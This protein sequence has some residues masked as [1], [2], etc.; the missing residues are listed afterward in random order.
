MQIIFLPEDTSPDG[1]IWSELPSPEK[2]KGKILFKGKGNASKGEEPEESEDEDMVE[3]DDGQGGG[4]GAADGDGKKK[5]KKGKRKKDRKAKM[6]EGQHK[7]AKKDKELAKDAKRKQ[8]ETGASKHDSE[9]W[10]R[11]IYLCAVKFKSFT[12]PGPAYE[13]ASYSESKARKLCST[14]RLAFVEYNRKQLA[15]IYPWGGRVD[16]SNLDPG[17]A[18]A[19]GCQLVAF[20]FQVLRCR[21]LYRSAVFG[22]FSPYE[23][24]VPLSLTDKST[25]Q[26]RI[27]INLK[28]WQWKSGL[29]DHHLAGMTGMTLDL[30]VC[31]NPTLLSLHKMLSVQTAAGQNARHN[32]SVSRLKL[33]ALQT[34]I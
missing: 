20:N 14:Q 19:A 23:A 24:G 7:G 27:P 15:R 9:R 30:A 4:G 28:S 12:S 33:A 1:E 26:I 2:L 13:M 8:Q 6:F 5:K 34:A 18:W 32:V 29:P 31:T 25:G 11:I 16:S 21:V 3:L 10:V 17:L 22:R